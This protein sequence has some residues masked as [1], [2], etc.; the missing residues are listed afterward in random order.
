MFFFLLSKPNLYF[1]FKTTNTN[2]FSKTKPYNNSYKRNLTWHIKNLIITHTNIF[3]WYMT[4]TRLIST[5]RKYRMDPLLATGL[6]SSLAVF[7]FTSV[8]AAIVSFSLTSSA[9]VFVVCEEFTWFYY[10]QR[11]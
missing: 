3:T 1:N 11:K 7:I 9:V 4:L 5:M 10:E 2:V 6:N 8:S